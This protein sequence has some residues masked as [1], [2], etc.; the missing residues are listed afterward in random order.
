MEG[1]KMQGQYNKR[2]VTILV[3]IIALSGMMYG[4]N[5]SNI[6]RLYLGGAELLLP[7]HREG[8]PLGIQL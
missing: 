6:S 7:H 1:T 4:M 3:F 2:Y 5:W 8:Q